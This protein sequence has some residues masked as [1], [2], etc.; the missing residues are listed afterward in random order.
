MRKLPRNSTV[1]LT[2]EPTWTGVIVRHAGDMTL[3]SWVTG[4]LAGDEK[5]T[6]TDGIGSLEERTSILTAAATSEVRRC[7]TATP[8]AKSA[9]LS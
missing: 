6:G 8:A 9:P 4:P 2:R 3:V 5:W 7:R 1:Y